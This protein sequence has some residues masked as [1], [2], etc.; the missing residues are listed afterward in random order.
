MKSEDLIQHAKRLI[1][2]MKQAQSQDYAMDLGT[3]CPRLHNI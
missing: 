2:G 1:E 3:L